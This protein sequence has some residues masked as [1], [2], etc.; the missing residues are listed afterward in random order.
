MHLGLPVD[1]IER[2]S[3][4]L[5][6]LRFFV[7]VTMIDILSGTSPGSPGAFLRVRVSVPPFYG[8]FGS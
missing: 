6:Q 2:L 1:T 4:N 3:A 5:A 7:R 8:D